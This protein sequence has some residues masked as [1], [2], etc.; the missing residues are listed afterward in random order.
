MKKPDV[1]TELAPI[2]SIFKI[3]SFTLVN[4]LKLTKYFS[5]FSKKSLYSNINASSTSTQFFIKIYLKEFLKN[6]LNI[7]YKAEY[8][9]F[10]YFIV[11]ETRRQ[12]FV[13]LLDSKKRS[14][15]TYSTGLLLCSMGLKNNNMYKSM[16]KQSK[17][18]I[19]GFN[20]AKSFVIPKF[21]NRNQKILKKIGFIIKGRGKFTTSYS[22]L[23]NYFKRFKTETLFLIWV[24]SIRFSYVKFRQYGRIKR[25]FR[26]RIVKSLTVSEKLKTKS[27]YVNVG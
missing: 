23:P 27:S 8:S 1:V 9:N 2:V 7:S 4:V 22:E 10:N 3:R 5:F 26:K 20:F 17:G 13:S 25:N 14:Q 19:K 24:P 21:F 15:V 16:K 11:K 6:F 12:S 18:F